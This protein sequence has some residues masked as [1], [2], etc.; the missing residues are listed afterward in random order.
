MD[1]DLLVLIAVMVHPPNEVHMLITGSS[2]KEK[3]VQQQEGRG[4][5]RG[6]ERLDHVHPW[7]DGV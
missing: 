5:P 6:Y 7:H 2:F 4:R 1:A 3:N